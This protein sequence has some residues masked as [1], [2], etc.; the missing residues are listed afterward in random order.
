MRPPR[1]LAAAPA[2]AMAAVPPR[3]EPP[4]AGRCARRLS[5]VRDETFP[6]AGPVGIR[7]K[8]ESVT[9]FDRFR[10]EEAR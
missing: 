4:S 7:S 3:A 10:E 5:A 6:D 2:L 1:L 9:E 8:A